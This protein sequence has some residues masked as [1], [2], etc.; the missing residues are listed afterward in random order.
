MH[1]RFHT[2]N[3]A[4][5]AMPGDL[6]SE[7]SVAMGK[8]THRKPAIFT[9]ARETITEFFADDC[10]SQA[11]ALA[12]STIFSLP[13]LLLIVVSVLG[14]VFGSEAAQDRVLFE[15]SSLIGSRAGEQIKS[16]LAETQR[17]GISHG[18]AA[19]IGICALIIG[20][21]SAFGQLQSALN[22]AW[23]VKPDPKR[24]EIRTF[25]VK[26]LVS[27][28]MILGIAFLAMVSL[29]LSAGLAAFGDVLKQW[30][31][32]GFSA[33]LLEAMN[34]ILSLAIFG[35]LFA[36]MHRFLPD[37]EISWPDAAVGGAMTAILF[38]VG[39]LLIGLYIGNSNVTS[40]YGAA[41]SLAVI[42]LWT[43]YSSMILLLGAELTQV[44][45]RHHGRV[46]PPE[47]GAMKV[48]Q[49]EVPVG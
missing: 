22:Q 9:I 43:Y 3:T 18:M 30:L 6:T 21:T 44:W 5:D 27:F 1:V 2:A 33:P 28:G 11:G 35:I 12:Y 34:A 40:V 37:A 10:P 19:L 25:L 16:M 48:E 41:G 46:A 14:S 15:I 31:P 7:H 39:K 38:T 13:P 8:R 26:R 45:S 32:S 4:T 36:T 47:A 20:A 42:L 29:L 24:G 23:N 49:L 17:S